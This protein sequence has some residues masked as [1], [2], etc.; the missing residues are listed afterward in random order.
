M[1]LRDLSQKLENI[2]LVKASN[3]TIQ[4]PSEQVLAPR[5][6]QKAYAKRSQPKVNVAEP[7]EVMLNNVA[8]SIENILK[9][10]SK[11]ASAT[12]DGNL[13]LILT[14]LFVNGIYIYIS[15]R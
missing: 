1:A 12:T 4:L 2:E 8:T 3:I 15:L 13:I 10:N 7:I 9:S 6:T 11:E 5:P 14:C